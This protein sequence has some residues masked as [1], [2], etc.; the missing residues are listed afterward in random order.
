MAKAIFAQTNFT[1]G[2]IT[3]RM[4]GRGDIARYQNG[5]EIIEN[6]IVLVHGGVKRR[7]GLRF[8]REAKLAGARKVRAIR[9][10]YNIKQSYCLEFGHLYVRVLDGK[11]GATIL[12]S[13]GVNPLEIVSPYTEDQ[14]ADVT[15]KQQDDTLFLYHPSVPTQQL[16]RITATLWTLLPVRWIVEPFAELGH[17]PQF[18]VTLSA[19]TVGTGR[20]FTSS[21]AAVPGAP[22]GASATPFNASATVS[23]TPPV[24]NGGADIISYTATSSPGGLTGTSTGSPITV[25]GLTNGV[26]Y[27]FTV[28]ATNAV[29]NSAASGATGSVTPLAS[30]GGGV[31]TGSIAPSPFGKN[32]ANGSNITVY[33]PTA[34]GTSGTPPYSYLWTKLSGSSSVTVK[35]GNAAQ[36]VLASNGASVTNVFALRCQIVDANGNSITVDVNGSIAHITSGGGGGGGGGGFPPGT[37]IP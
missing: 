8:L 27:T 3:P 23:F 29:G 4:L 9:Y 28:V 21:A 1:A 25:L 7:Y 5:A 30:L 22:T 37:I 11:T 36:V 35:T 15:H 16:R 10:V 14:L 6:G 32:V 2:E 31:I 17:T 20:T 33:G 12:D 18:K 24:S 19:T 13:G 26:A 34:G